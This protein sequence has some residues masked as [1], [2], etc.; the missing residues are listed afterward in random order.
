MKVGPKVKER[1]HDFKYEE[2]EDVTNLVTATWPDGETWA[3]SGLTIEEYKST[4]GASGGIADE[5]VRHVAPKRRRKS[6]GSTGDTVWTGHS[7]DHGPMRLA[8][9][10]SR[11]EQ[12]SLWHDDQQICQLK[13]A[14]TGTVL[15][16]KAGDKT[17]MELAPVAVVVMKK[18]GLEL[19][20]SE[21][22]LENRF[23]RRNELMIEHDLWNKKVKVAKKKRGGRTEKRGGRT[24]RRCGGIACCRYCSWSLCLL[25]VCCVPVFI[26]MLY[27]CIVVMFVLVYALR[28]C[29]ILCVVP[30]SVH[31]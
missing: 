3:V 19:L 29:F 31:F 24:K 6:S 5:E 13:V 15:S 18:L 7:S 21:T 23:V 10:K 4:K 11:G 26:S 2:G 12:L 1:A 22:K 16:T 25:C 8:W 9:R 30:R 28:S 27:F 17:G 14:S 20:N